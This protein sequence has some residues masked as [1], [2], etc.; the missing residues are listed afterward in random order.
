M[1]NFNIKA[2]GNEATIE[3]LGSIGESWFD[4]GHTIN[5]VKSQI[6]EITANKI[7]LKISSLGGDAFEGLAIHDLLKA[8]KAK[9]T[10]KI[11][12][13]TAS[14]G[15]II[16][17]GADKVEIS[18]NSLFLVHNAWTMAGGNAADLRKQAENLETVDNRMAA[19]YVAKTG[20]SEEEV[21][22]L[23]SEDKWIDAD[24][25]KEFGFVDTVTAPLKAVASAI[26]VINGSKELPNINEK[27]K[28][29]INKSEFKMTEENKSWLSEQFD[30][31]KGAIAPKAEVVPEEPKE[32]TVLKSEVD[33][34]L[35][36]VNALIETANNNTA[37][38]EAKLA[39][40]QTELENAN[41]ALANAQATKVEAKGEDNAP[42]AE[43][44]DSEFD[45]TYNSVKA[46]IK[47]KRLR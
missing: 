1:R 36:E 38:L 6:E 32:E 23:M 30:A 15:T 2:K 16:A 33:K 45:A 27:L 5:T 41:K 12:G 22:T 14:A 34:Q 31:I 37:E 40:A 18:E 28:S 47:S 21:R 13:A 7:T 3:I 24:E 35:E 8:S 44:K 17:L 20:K 29:K 9:V 39:E 11:I 46:L 25:A 26:N 4:E 10:A 43:Q 19:I 42:D